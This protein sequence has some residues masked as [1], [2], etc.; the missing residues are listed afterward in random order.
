[1]PINAKNYAKQH[2]FEGEM[3][4]KINKRIYPEIDEIGVMELVQRV[5]EGE[6]VDGIKIE[7][8]GV[9]GDDKTSEV[10]KNYDFAAG[11]MQGATRT[12]QAPSDK[13]GKTKH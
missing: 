3:R 1:M 7:Y 8:F 4:V 12:E 9:R 6:E 11:F 5:M 13:K 10:S 2:S